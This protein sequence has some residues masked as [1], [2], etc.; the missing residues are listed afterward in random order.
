LG[1][2]SLHSITAKFRQSLDEVRRSETQLTLALSLVIGALVGLVIVA[3][4]LLT[5]RLSAACILREGPVGD[6]FWCRR[7]AR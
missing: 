7:W 4:I 6:G 1:F 3:F 5:G 2:S